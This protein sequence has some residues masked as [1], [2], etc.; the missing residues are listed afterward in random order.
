MGREEYVETFQLWGAVFRLPVSCVYVDSFRKRPPGLMLWGMDQMSSVLHLCPKHNRATQEIFM[1]L[2]LGDVTELIYQR[3]RSF[4]LTG[5]ASREE[6]LRKK[7][8][9]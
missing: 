9:E 7:S 5:P 8:L 2:K 3:I 1:Q 6:D 4:P